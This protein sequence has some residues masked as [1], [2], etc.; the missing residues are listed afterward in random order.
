[1]GC[2]GQGQLR[3][4]YVHAKQCPGGLPVSL[5]DGFAVEELR[6][7]DQASVDLRLVSRETATQPFFYRA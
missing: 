1:M 3:I 6:V 7:S 2:H 5:Q 4:G